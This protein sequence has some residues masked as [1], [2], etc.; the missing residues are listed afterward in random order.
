MVMLSRA[1]MARQRQATSKQ[2]AAAAIKMI[3]VEGLSAWGAE[4]L[5]LIHEIRNC[6]Q[7]A[8]AT[9]LAPSKIAEKVAFIKLI[10]IKNQQTVQ[11]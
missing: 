8:E 3:E 9:R 1:R 5:K 6:T 4:R 11:K 10:N 2:A 7:V